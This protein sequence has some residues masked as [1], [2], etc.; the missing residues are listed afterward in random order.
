[1]PGCRKPRLS[2]YPAGEEVKGEGP[3]GEGGGLT[4]GSHLPE[5]LLC[6]NWGSRAGCST[7]RMWA[8]NGSMTRRA[9]EVPKEGQPLFIHV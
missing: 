6:L 9:P 4:T 8:N 1:M 7:R 5:P 2:N 3:W